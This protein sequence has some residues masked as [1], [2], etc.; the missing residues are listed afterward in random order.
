MT[1]NTHTQTHT[2]IKEVPIAGE[3]HCTFSVVDPSSL[4]ITALILLVDL[5]N[6]C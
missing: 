3:I 6:T 2:L 4:T 5:G 1:T